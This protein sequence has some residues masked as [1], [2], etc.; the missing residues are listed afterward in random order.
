MQKPEERLLHLSYVTLEGAWIK[1]LMT[2]LRSSLHQ[3]LHMALDNWGSSGLGELAIAIATKTTVIELIRERIDGG[4]R[5]LSEDIRSRRDQVKKDID[6]GYGFSPTEK[7]LGYKLVAD[8]DSFL[9]E[10]RSAYEIGVKFVG[11]FLEVVL[12]HPQPSKSQLYAMVRDEIA[13]RG[14][15]TRW[16]KVLRESR[17]EFLHS[18]ASWPAVKI[19]SF[20]P[21]RA[22]LVLLRNDSYLEMAE[23]RDIYK[24]FWESLDAL[25]EWLSDEIDRWRPTG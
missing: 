5:F 10:T 2:K 18:A 15:D 9:F 20:D 7:M 12:E 13:R 14:K 19:I 1:R 17:G 16:L 3:H 21:L 22:E 11:R 6:E 4:L 25:E 23:C 24:G 8:F